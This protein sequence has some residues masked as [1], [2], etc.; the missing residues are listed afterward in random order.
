MNSLIGQT[1]ASAE[2]ELKQLNYRIIREDKTTYVITCDF[3]L[4][5]LNLEVDNGIITT[6]SYG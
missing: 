3:Q 2:K 6:V 5:R 1:L 4:D